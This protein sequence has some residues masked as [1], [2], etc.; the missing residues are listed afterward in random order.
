MFSVKKMRYGRP[1]SITSHTAGSGTSNSC[2][3]KFTGGFYL[4]LCKRSLLKSKSIHRLLTE[5][6]TS[7]IH[8][9]YL[10]LQWL[11]FAIS[12]LFPTALLQDYNSSEKAQS[13]QHR[14]LSCYFAIILGHTT[15]LSTEGIILG[16]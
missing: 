10:V 13:Q 15:N 9:G 6:P 14:F 12:S 5:E 2:K 4:T 3:W 7:K 11:F 16:R 8:A 1:N